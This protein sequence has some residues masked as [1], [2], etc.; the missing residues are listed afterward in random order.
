MWVLNSKLEIT[1]LLEYIFLDRLER[2][3]FAQSSHE[4]LITQVQYNYFNNISS[5][6]KNIEL[7]FFHC[8]KGK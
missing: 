3:K 1:V 4:Y 8:G 5:V 6:N 7:N 2:K